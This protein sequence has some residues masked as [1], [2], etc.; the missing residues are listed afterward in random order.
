M[1]IPDFAINFAG[2]FLRLVKVLLSLKPKG[3]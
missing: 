2:P 3:E 1:K